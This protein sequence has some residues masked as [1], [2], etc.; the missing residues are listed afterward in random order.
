M[1]AVRGFRFGTAEAD[2]V[3][4]LRAERASPRAR[5]TWKRGG[6]GRL[7]PKTLAAPGGK[8]HRTFVRVA[9]SGRTRQ[10]RIVPRFPCWLLLLCLTSFASASDEPWFTRTWSTDDGLPNNHVTGITQ[11]PEGDLL[12][13]TRTG[14]AKFDGL[15]F[16]PTE[17]VSPESD[18]FKSLRAVTRSGETWVVKGNNI[19][20]LRGNEFT[21]VDSHNNPRIAAASDGG[22]WVA[23]DAVLDKQMPD[24]TTTV[25][26]QF[27]T[28]GPRPHVTALREDRAG[29][30]WIGTATNGLFHYD[31]H[32]FQQID[33]S[34]AYI[35]C[36]T[37]DSEGNFWVG[38]DGGGLNRIA[39]RFVTLERFASEPLAVGI[40]SVCED[41]TG[42]IWGV[43][44]NRWLVR[45]EN[46]QWRRVMDEALRPV[47]APLCVVAD[48]NGA[49]W[50]GTARRC[51]FRWRDGQLTR[52]GVG[53]GMTSF[54]VHSFLPATNG[55]VWVGSYNPHVLQRLRGDKLETLTSPSPLT[56]IRALCEDATGNVWV[57]T[58]HGL[59]VVNQG[60][61]KVT[62]VDL[63]GPGAGESIATLIKTED[64]TIW[65]GCA[66]RGLIRLRDGR[67]ARIGVDRGLPDGYIAQM[68]DDGLGWLWIGSADH[69]IYKVRF[70]QLD[71]ALTNPSFRLRPIL[72]GRNE[73]LLRLEAYGAHSPDAIGPSAIRTRDGRIWIPMRTAIAVIQP[74]LAKDD[75]RPVP[76]RLTRVVID[77]AAAMPPLRIDPSHSRIDFEFSVV[78]LTS[79]E[80][81]HVRY[82]L[83]G[84]DSGWNEAGAQRVASYS[85]LAPGHYRFR[86]QSANGDGAWSDAQAPVGVVVLPFYWQTWW[87]RLG[88]L[89]AF[90]AITGGL[91]HRIS[92]RRLRAQHRRLEQQSALDRERARIA[93]DL[94]DDLGG[95]LTQVSVMLDLAQKDP[96]KEAQAKL[97]RCVAL[98]RGAAQSVDEI[99]WAINPRND[100]LRY[101]IDYLSQCVVE[102]FH[103]ANIECSVELPETIPDRPVTPEARHHLLLVVKECATNVTRHAHATEVR[104]Q[105]AVEA[106]RLAIALEDNGKGFAAAPDNATADGLRNMRDRM[107][108]IGG[109]FHIENRPGGGTRA[110]LVYRWSCP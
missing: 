77:G 49:V 25:I 75:P 64:G 23:Y 9:R 84:V 61:N 76:V 11:T 22:L 40:Q 94:H 87:F 108:E 97:G 45:L 99:I 83:E 73:G 101:L 71:R 98:V 109:T 82:W 68:V 103:A 89:A 100:T 28:S 51:F 62:P 15:H 78:N 46:G 38:T 27:V 110:C 74:K 57:G 47:D 19:G 95:S 91:V 30:V 80:N 106:D 13:M 37:E 33:T 105:V 107:A 90:T 85:R 24:G 8:R 5:G 39:R 59:F 104:L 14:A 1:V 50:I 29:G 63:P 93:R 96:A 81:S 52:W 58:D 26:G 42:Q 31:G 12:V 36:I 18:D 7:L 4:G 56:A 88:T 21:P 17:S 3:S 34:Y 66:G 10:P 72:Y 55:D 32:A 54:S 20:T 92:N 65:A 44:Q 16:T 2:G 41:T 43:T 70:D 6:G 102:S 60:E 53:D 79:P 35:L 86:L 48:R 67:A 69:G